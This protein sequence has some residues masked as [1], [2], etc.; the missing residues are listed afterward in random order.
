MGPESRSQLHP[1]QNP[2]EHR[3]FG[4]NQPISMSPTMDVTG[5]LA[6]DQGEPYVVLLLQLK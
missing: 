1:G 5:S 3:Q 4:R 2:L 6:Q